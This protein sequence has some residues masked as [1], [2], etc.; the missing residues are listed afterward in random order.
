MLG[1][2]TMAVV[3]R[4]NSIHTFR[5][6]TVR[7]LKRHVEVGV[8]AALLAF[9]LAGQ[10]SYLDH[11]ATLLAMVDWETIATLAGIILITTA[12]RSSH[13]FGKVA[14]G[15]LT[16]IGSERT[17][18]I[19]LT[20]LTAGMATF[21]T[22]DISLLIIVP[23]T[24][25]LQDHLDNDITKIVVFEAL[26]ANVGSALTPI[27]NPQNLFL[28]HRWGLP[29]VR[30]VEAMAAP[31]G[32]MLVLLFVLMWFAFRRR[33]LSLKVR[34]TCRFRPRVAAFSLAALVAYVALSEFRL[35][36]YAFLPLLALFFIA[37]RDAVR[38]ADWAL[39]ALFM[40]MFVDF[41]MLAA[42]QPV[43]RML[44]TLKG[45]GA[46]RVFLGS[47]LTSQ[48]ISNV[49]AAI[50]VSQFS[51]SWRAIAYGV[52]LGGNGLFIGSLANL[53]AL[54]MANERRVWSEFHIYS[55]PYL[56]VTAALVYLLLL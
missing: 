24:L 48:V 15:V 34:E 14:A 4:S 2:V 32:L 22:N 16:H 42:V 17:L 36:L 35:S 11:P 44:S 41:R 8:L 45:D 39:V 43:S 38:Q 19:T 37:D 50:L 9:L 52:N 29:F 33:S 23:I 28:W 5:C 7:M 10:R 26:A 47:I 55:L 56:A 21:L 12:I 54:K 25:S 27:G 31:V 30:F 1:S 49:P 46:G 51:H 40:L 18:A 13:L 20:A 53:I 3:N 6:R